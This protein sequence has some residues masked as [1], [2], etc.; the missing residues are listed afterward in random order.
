M[1]LPSVSATFSVGVGYQCQNAAPN[2]Q[3]QPITAQGNPKKA[4]GFTTGTNTANQV[5]EL[6]SKIYSVAAGGTANIDLTALLDVLGNTV[7]L[8]RV[9]GLLFQLLST[10]DDA[11]NGTACSGVTIGN[12]GSNAFQM[13]LGA[14]AHTIVLGNGEAAAWLSPSAGG[15]TVNGTHK[16]VLITN[17]DVVNPAAVQVT[18]L[19]ADA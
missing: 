3:Y 12:A 16:I 8:V 4:I 6:S 10:A 19:G 14:Q 5:D 17:N 7:S 2:S 9:K 1:G 11:T 15:L 18:V 13:F